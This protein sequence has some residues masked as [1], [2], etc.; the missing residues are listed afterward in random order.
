IVI[1]PT[2]GFMRYFYGLF[3]L[4]WL[5]GW[6]FGFTA[7]VHQLLFGKFQLFLAAWL[8]AWILGGIFAS[9]AA[10]RTLRPSVPETLQFRRNSFAYDSGLA[11][12]D[13]SLGRRSRNPFQSWKAMFPKRRRLELDRSQL[14][15]LR[16][17][18]TDSGNRL[19]FDIG[20]ERIEIAPTA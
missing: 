7:A 2:S 18:E 20:S 4:C 17:R 19:T 8:A 6:A 1:P 12:P 5:V 3:M 10:Y 14:Q 9:F 16:L 11:P 13:F 15:S